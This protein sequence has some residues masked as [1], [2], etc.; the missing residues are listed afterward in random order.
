A[1]HYE[2]W[3]RASTTWQPSAS[4]TRAGRRR[5]RRHPP[6]MGSSR[7]SPSR[8]GLG[9][10]NRQRLSEGRSHLRSA[11]RALLMGLPA[12]R[13]VACPPPTADAW[14][15]AV[16]HRARSALLIRP[17]RGLER[18]LTALV[19]RGQ[20]SGELAR[21]AD[22]AAVGRMLAVLL[23]GITASARAGRP[24]AQLEA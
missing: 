10:S 11:A 4:R 22:A 21:S 24:K 20:E 15:A 2:E 16:A 13:A 3:L 12:G 19:G 18:A 9:S 5:R 1:A 6:W 8:T 17:A 14:R 23:Q 7:R